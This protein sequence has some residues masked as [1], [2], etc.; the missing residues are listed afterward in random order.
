MKALFP[1]HVA[2]FN[3][4]VSQL[5]R[6]PAGLLLIGRRGT[7]K[8]RFANHL[9]RGL[10]CTRGTKGC[11]KCTQCRQFLLGH[12][13]DFH[14]LTTRS[15]LD[16]H[17]D[18]PI[19]AGERYLGGIGKGVA[20]RSISVDQVRAL[21]GALVSTAHG[22][23]AKVV[24]I[25]TADDMNPNAANALLKVLEEPTD[26][27]FFLMGCR[28][29]ARIAATIRSR[30][31]VVPLAVPPAPELHKYLAGL[32]PTTQTVLERA[33]TVGHGLPE[34]AET[35]IL[36]EGEV[37]SDLE[38]T[39]AI[40]PGG[41]IKGEM[42]TSLDGD[43]LRLVLPRIQ[44]AICRQ[45]RLQLRGLKGGEFA[46]VSRLSARNV[47]VYRA[48]GQFLTATPGTIDERLFVEHILTALE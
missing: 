46:E 12:H 21:T 30:C 26:N 47:R 6:I 48:I 25:M 39:H 42:L 24:L 36:A 11:G 16:C 43:Q 1:W 10:L 7:G 20:G 40:E 15:N 8:L 33:A 3:T 28:M 23:C 34:V 38:W 19:K 41:N 9:A 31:M 13:P 5:D 2:A 44:Q 29:P 27:T 17:D 4:I 32:N 22:P 37:G 45:L 18:S 14:V 35:M